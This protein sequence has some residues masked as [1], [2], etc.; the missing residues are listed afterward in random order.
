MEGPGKVTTTTEPSSGYRI[1]TQPLLAEEAILLAIEEAPA[2]LR[3]SFFAERDRLY[4]IA[5]EE[6][7]ERAFAELHGRWW[8]R[9]ELG[10]TLHAA[11][12]R[13]RMLARST[14]RCAVLPAAGKQEF[15][16]LHDDGTGA[17]GPPTLVLH[18]R[19]RTLAHPDRLERLLERELLF[20]GDLLDPAFG[21]ERGLAAD[22]PG[23]ES[24]VLG[25]YRVLWEVTVDGRLCARGKLEPRVGERRRQE[26][27][28]AFPMLGADTDAAFE[29]FFRG[30]RPSHAALLAFAR[31]PAGRGDAG[32][33]SLCRLPCAELRPGSE[34]TPAIA[35]LITGDFPGWE[36]GSLVCPQCAELYRARSTSRSR[37]PVSIVSI[38]DDALGTIGK[39]TAT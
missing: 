25:R 20:I 11:L 31:D 8:E 3:R 5:D 37:R 39:E 27:R 24:L 26:F 34:L 32:R 15:A 1:E 10:K 28:A 23:S 14:A 12:A 7:R 2:A 29:R 33:C 17:D 36:A 4:E 21:F 9:L 19:P 13:E 6:T 16:D 18:L 35:R 22:G 30:E 38:E